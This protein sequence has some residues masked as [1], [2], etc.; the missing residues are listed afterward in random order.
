MLGKRQRRSIKQNKRYMN[1]VEA[2]DV[3][4]RSEGIDDE[5]EFDEDDES[6]VEVK[7]KN[8]GPSTGKKQN[9]TRQQTSILKKWFIMHADYPYLKEDN[10]NELA[11]KTGLDPRQVSNWFTNVRKRIWQPIKKRNKNKGTKDLMLKVKLRLESDAG[12]VNYDQ[13]KKLSKQPDLLGRPELK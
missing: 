12:S 9:F 4:P 6:L 5:D 13:D 10:R 3:R 1:D 8:G 2:S 11:R 7:R